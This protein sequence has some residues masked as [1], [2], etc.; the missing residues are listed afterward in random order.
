MS[1]AEIRRDLELGKTQQFEAT[2]LYTRVFA[3]A[4]KLSGSAVPR[5]VLPRILLQSPKITRKLTTEWFAQRVDE[6]HKRCMA[7]VSAGGA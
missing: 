3:L 2:R 7:R 5:A 1:A 6:R 4:E